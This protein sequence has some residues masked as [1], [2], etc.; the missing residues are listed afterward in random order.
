MKI[1]EIENLTKSF[2]SNFEVVSDCTFNIQAGN[3]S[4][5]YTHLRAHET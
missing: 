1:L 4:V 5:S 2:E 3:I